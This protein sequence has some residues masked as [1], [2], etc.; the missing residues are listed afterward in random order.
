MPAGRPTDYKPEY[1]EQGRKLCELGATDMEMAEFFKVDIRTIYNWKHSH[2]EFFQAVIVGKEALDDRVERSLYQRA[3]GY[4]FNSEKIFH[5]QGAITRADTIEHVP[6]DPSAALNWLKNR[7][8][9]KWRDK[10]DHAVTVTDLAGI[11]AARRSRVS[12]MVDGE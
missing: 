6:P 1:A 3:V 9:E 4:S 2:V 8:G 7:R 12:E 11:I 10:V 5:H